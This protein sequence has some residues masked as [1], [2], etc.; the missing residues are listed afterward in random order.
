[1]PGLAEACCDSS[2]YGSRQSIEFA[3]VVL[4][5]FLIQQQIILEPNETKI[6]NSE[7]S[8][9]SEPPSRHSRL[10]AV[11]LDPDCN[12]VETCSLEIDTPHEAEIH[13][14]TPDL[15]G[16]ATKSA[17]KILFH[18]VHPFARLSITRPDTLKHTHLL[19][20]EEATS[21]VVHNGEPGKDRKNG[22][23]CDENRNRPVQIPP[24]DEGPAEV[25]ALSINVYRGNTS[26]HLSLHTLVPGF[27][28]DGEI[29]EPAWFSEQQL[30]IQET[31]SVNASLLF[32]QV[33]GSP[34]WHDRFR[35]EQ[36]ISNWPSLPDEVGK[37]GLLVI[38]SNHWLF[39][40][41]GPVIWRAVFKKQAP[42]FELYTPGGW[43]TATPDLL[44]VLNDPWYETSFWKW[45][46]EYLDSGSG[47]YGF[48]TPN[49]MALAALFERWRQEDVQANR[50]K[51]KKGRQEKPGTPLLLLPSAAEG[52]QMPY[53]PN[54]K[55]GQPGRRG[56]P[57]EPHHRAG[58]RYQAP[59]GQHRTRT[60]AGA[61]GY[62]PSPPSAHARFH[63]GRGS[64]GRN[65]P[66]GEK[67]RLEQAFKQLHQE[68][69]EA[70]KVA[71][72]LLKS[73]SPEYNEYPQMIQLKSGLILAWGISRKHWNFI[74][75]FRIQS[76]T[77]PW[78]LIW[79]GQKCSKD[80]VE[81]MRLSKFWSHYISVLITKELVV[82]PSLKNSVLPC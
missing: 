47:P 6:V 69:H 59:H 24:G 12:R 10:V 42:S 67:S 2:G 44:G 48:S 23:L 21:E 29:I 20:L 77:L 82:N 32:V 17:D 66:E 80:W 65:I 31:G 40:Q 26:E 15:C 25:A 71:N 49:N 78:I 45:L 57:A 64:T 37:L 61:T 53:G 39:N 22:R 52:K 68:P 43:R 58:A 62:S 34:V 9:F 16:Q 35:L 28:A 5:Q 79:H 55:R 54:G 74:H 14:L 11:F 18:P 76:E 8:V 13:C 56:Q 7:S 30:G 36:L 63:T 81:R 33:K 41:Q 1:M 27:I 46:F 75:V 50:K 72:N 73:Y 19:V 3:G 70:L 38:E 4:W 51:Q 60:Q